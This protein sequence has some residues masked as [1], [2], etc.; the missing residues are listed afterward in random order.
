MR[1]VIFPIALLLFAANARA[2]YINTVAGTGAAGYFGDGGPATS[3]TL[4]N[5]VDVVLGKNKS[6][7]ISL[8]NTSVIRKVDS[9]GVITTVAGTGVLG[10]GGD[11]GPA[12]L[13]RLYNPTGLA[14]DTAGN[15]FI[16]DPNNHVV[17]KVS[18]A[19]IITTFAG[20]GG[21]LGHTGDGGPATAARMYTPI[22]ITFDKYGNL[23]IAEADNHIIR[24]VSTSGII[25]TIAGTSAGFSGDGGPATAAQ[26]N[27]PTGLVFDTTGNLFVADQR[28]HRIR[29]INTSGTISTYAGIGTAGFSGDGGPAVS[30]QLDHPTGVEMHP[31]GNLLIAETNHVRM[32]NTTGIITTIAGNG[33]ST[34]SGDGGPATAAGVLAYRITSD[35]AG[36]IYI[37][38]SVQNRIRTFSLSCAAPSAGSITAADTVCTCSKISLSETIA[39]GVWSATNENAF[40]AINGALLGY[41]AGLDTI[42]YS[43]TNICGTSVASKIIYVSSCSSPLRIMKTEGTLSIFPNPTSDE[44]VIQ[45][46]T[47]IYHVDVINML[48]QQLLSQNCASREVFVDMKDYPPGT[49]VIK[50]ND[51]LS[52]QV[53]KQ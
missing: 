25:S 19:G 23:F 51:L 33:S 49:Y 32:I 43:V 13:A 6:Y 27:Y 20:I 3:A 44:L 29:K 37:S 18:T 21:A 24:K 53:V 39:G 47:T 30:A 52:N 22:D 4:D 7:F 35:T 48:G 14:M 38:G 10:F 36:K 17:R 40:L 2:Q 15:L 34:F 41:Q 26:F 50:V 31:N 9:F 5:P 8:D 46:P 11:G 42:S 28:N 16:A 45:S 12:T 1:T